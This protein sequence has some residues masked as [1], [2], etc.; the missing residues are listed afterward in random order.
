MRINYD[1]HAFYELAGSDTLLKVSAGSGHSPPNE[2]CPPQLDYVC[3][4]NVI[5]M[6]DEYCQPGLPDIA[7]PGSGDVACV[8]NGVCV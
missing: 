7:C 2:S 6:A 3:E 1:E 5:C 8:Q 4:A